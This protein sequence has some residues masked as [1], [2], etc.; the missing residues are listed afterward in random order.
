MKNCNMM[1]WGLYSYIFNY[2]KKDLKIFFFC[3]YIGDVQ[4]KSAL[5]NCA[6][7]WS[8]TN[9]IFLSKFKSNVYTL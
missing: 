7:T 4:M 8:R 6:E 3:E 2:Y 1:M 5:L 9:L